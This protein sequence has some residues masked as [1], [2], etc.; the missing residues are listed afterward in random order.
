[1][2][3]DRCVDVSE[4]PTPEA[5][6]SARS[7]RALGVGVQGLADV[8]MQLRLPFTSIGARELNISI[9]ETLYYAALDASCRLAESYGPYPDWVGSPAARG[10]LQVDLWGVTPSSRHDFPGLR[11]RIARFGLRNSVITALMPTASTSKLLGN[12]ESFEPYTRYSIS[13]L[14]PVRCINRMILSNVLVMRTGSGDY[15]LICPHLVRDLASRGLWTDVVRS[16]LQQHHG[17]LYTLSSA[18]AY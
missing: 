7:T 4:Y 2:N 13:Y 6:A 10:V 9:F 16:Y 18:A 15:P 17:M 8:F 3:A 1:M 14:V 11:S 12:F 5:A